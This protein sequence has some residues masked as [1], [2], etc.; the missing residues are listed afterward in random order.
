MRCEIARLHCVDIEFLE[1]DTAGPIYTDSTDTVVNGVHD[2]PKYPH[3]MLLLRPE[4][5]VAYRA[6]KLQKWIEEKVLASREKIAEAEAA[7]V[8]A[9]ESTAE[10]LP[11]KAIANVGDTAEE[12]IA[13]APPQTVINAADFKLSFNPDAFVERAPGDGGAKA[14]VIY[15]PEAESTKEVRNASVWL[16]ESGI[17]GFVI[18]AVLSN[19]GFTDGQFL[20]KLMHRKGINVRYLGLLAKAVDQDGPTL[21]YGKNATKD[22]IAFGLKGF[23]VGSVFSW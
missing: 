20:T 21:D 1:K 19:V 6:S 22:E 3:R 15:D 23:K 8:A 12:I 17:P 14:T 10:A 4:L 2:A 18:D 9:G 7:K 16:R 11:V 13:N 5:L